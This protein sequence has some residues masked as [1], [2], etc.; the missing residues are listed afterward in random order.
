VSGLRFL[1]LVEEFYVSRNSFGSV[2]ALHT[3]HLQPDFKLLMTF[4]D[5]SWMFRGCF[6]DRRN[7]HFGKTEPR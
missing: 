5:V 2:S 4:P 1:N 6:V 7:W 3:V